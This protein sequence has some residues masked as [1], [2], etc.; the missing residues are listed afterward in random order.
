MVAEW[1]FKLLMVT[2][3]SL[4]AGVISKQLGVTDLWLWWSCGLA[5]AGTLLVLQL[6]E[7]EG[8]D[9]EST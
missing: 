6:D 3:F 7:G 1:S 9:D 2:A 8:L 4:L 5:G